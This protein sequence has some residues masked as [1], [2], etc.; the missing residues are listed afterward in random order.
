MSEYLYKM[1]M[2][3][4]YIILKPSNMKNLYDNKTE[5]ITELLYRE[6]DNIFIDADEH[7]TY[8]LKQQLQNKQEAQKDYELLLKMDNVDAEKMHLF[9]AIL[10]LPIDED[11]DNITTQDLTNHLLRDDWVELIMIY[12]Y[13]TATELCNNC[14]ALRYDMIEVFE[15]LDEE[16]THNVAVKI[17]IN[18][19]KRS[20]VYNYGLG[21]QLSMR[22]CGI[23]LERLERTTHAY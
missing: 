23:E 12:K 16:R 18:K 5:L 8:P 17:A 10:D 15:E 20:K 19:I 13:F 1:D 3:I 2:K 6:D 11:I 14:D 22:S 7:V 4:R 21:L 9:K